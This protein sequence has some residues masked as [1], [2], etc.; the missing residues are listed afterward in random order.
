MYPDY[1]YGMPPSYTQSPYYASP[2]D[3]YYGYAY[4]PPPPMPYYHEPYYGYG[5][6][7]PRK[8]EDQLRPT[9]NQASPRFARKRRAPALSA[10]LSSYVRG[11]CAC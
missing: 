5:G 6:D 4:G 2:Y 7:R 3:D 11:N 8:E 9:G 1:G 10:V